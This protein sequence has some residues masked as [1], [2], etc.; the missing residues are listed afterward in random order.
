M[1]PVNELNAVIEIL[2]THL[3]RQK[4]E[5]GGSVVVMMCG[6]AGWYIKLQKG[7]LM[8]IG[9]GKTTLSRRII[10]VFSTFSLLSIDAIIADRHGIY[11]V[12]YKPSQ[13]TQY[14]EEGRKLLLERFHDLLKQKQNMVLDRSFWSKRDRDIF[15]AS[16][17]HAGGS[18]VLVYFDV[19]KEVLWRRICERRAKG[20]NADSALDITPE[21]LNQYVSGFEVPNCEGE[22]V[23]FTT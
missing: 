20:L 16:I 8:K 1:D 9:A 11:N 13:Y 12:D 22:I 23:L 6:V 4:N 21:L 5:A 10:D 17:E 3:T 2:N 15:K 18:W 7:M 14:S 19:K